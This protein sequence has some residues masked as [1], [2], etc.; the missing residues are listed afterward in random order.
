[1]GQRMER[2]DASSDGISIKDHSKIVP[3]AKTKDRNAIY[4]TAE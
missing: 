4:F 2:E 3:F 1:M